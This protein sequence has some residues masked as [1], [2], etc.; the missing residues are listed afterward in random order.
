LII[1]AHARFTLTEHMFH[2]LLGFTC[3]DRV[4]LQALGY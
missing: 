3:Q 1:T 4:D 2:A